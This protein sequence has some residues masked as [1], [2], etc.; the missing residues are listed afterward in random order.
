[1][2]VP[3]AAALVLGVLAA[4][5]LHDELI[6]SRREHAGERADLAREYADKYAAWVAGRSP[7]EFDDATVEELVGRLEADREGDRDRVLTT[8]AAGDA[9]GTGPTRSGDDGT[10]ATSDGPDEV[11]R[12][13]VL[14]TA[15][16]DGPE[17][18]L[19]ADDAPTVVDL[20]AWEE[21][22][23]EQRE[24]AAGAVDAADADTDA[25][26]D[27]DGDIDDGVETIADTDTSVDAEEKAPDVAEADSIAVAKTK[28]RKPARLPLLRKRGA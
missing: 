14:V 7:V 8:V 27:I 19:D 24:P 9:D 22:V 11:S 1:L 17:L 4:I 5:A 23:R 20:V 6:R 13:P 25:D 28:S 3:A 21:R 12:L 18:W 2:R 15:D 26:G 16:A 10:A